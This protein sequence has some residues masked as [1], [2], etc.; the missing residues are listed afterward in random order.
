[1]IGM[2]PRPGFLAHSCYRLGLIRIDYS[3]VHE[4]EKQLII[5]PRIGR[6]RIGEALCRVFP[7]GSLLCGNL[8]V[9]FEEYRRSGIGR[10][11]VTE[12]LAYAKRVRVNRIYGS[13]TENDL[14]NWPGLIDWYKRIG[15]EALPPDD[16]CVGHAKFKIEMR[17]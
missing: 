8:E 16:E 11:L 13:V 17:F 1:M 15:F 6:T 5:R 14:K 9:F 4:D 7:E 12:V 2:R 3:P 10:R